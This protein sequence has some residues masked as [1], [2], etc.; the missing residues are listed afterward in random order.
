M[1]ECATTKQRRHG[2]IR[3]KRHSGRG[4]GARSAEPF[5]DNMFFSS[6][7]SLVVLI[8]AIVFIVF[9]VLAKF[10]FFLI[11]TTYY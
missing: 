9:I 7:P 1:S 6:R 10:H 5:F 4:L 3:R 8:V 11:P 2:I